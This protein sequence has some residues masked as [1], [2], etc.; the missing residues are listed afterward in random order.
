MT[1]TVEEKKREGKARPVHI[2]EKSNKNCGDWREICP[3]ESLGLFNE[4]QGGE[5]GEGKQ[6][7]RGCL[8]A[9]KIR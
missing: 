3:K 4:N 1:E 7:E 8:Y 5:K 2:W 9:M 6:A